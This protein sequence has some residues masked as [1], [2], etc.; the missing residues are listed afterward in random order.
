MD[1]NKILNV[2][3]SLAMEF[4]KHWLEPIQSR[5]AKSFPDLSPSELDEYNSICKSVMEFSNNL[6]YSMV[7]REGENQKDWKAAIL[8]SYPWINKEN[9]SHLFSQ[10]VYY[11]RK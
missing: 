10:G 5:L 9:L 4:G 11:A 3:L 7:E 8:R 2:G 6:V 1:R